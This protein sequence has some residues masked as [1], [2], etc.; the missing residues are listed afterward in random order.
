MG[1]E[2]NVSGSVCTSSVT[3]ALEETLARKRPKGRCPCFPVRSRRARFPSSEDEKNVWLAT[4]P[5][6]DK[7]LYVLRMLHSSERLRTFQ[8][9]RLA[10]VQSPRHEPWSASNIRRFVGARKR[11]ETTASGWYVMS[12]RCLVRKRSRLLRSSW[13]TRRILGAPWPWL[14]LPP[15]SSLS[16]ANRSTPPVGWT[17]RYEDTCTERLLKPEGPP[18]NH[19]IWCGHATF[20][21][22]YTI[23]QWEQLPGKYNKDQHLL[24]EKKEKNHKYE[25]NFF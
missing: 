24:P 12:G 18:Q 20:N 7:I 2:K 4:I 11:S 15:R 13:D 8:R 3:A 17:R 25:N 14:Q 23:S 9:P 10:E 19:L 5:L 21:Q 6:V 16:A 1:K 22:M